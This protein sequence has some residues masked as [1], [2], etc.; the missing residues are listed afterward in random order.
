MTMVD[1]PAALFAGVEPL[2]VFV[3]RL[4][5]KDGIRQRLTD[6]FRLPLRKRRIVRDEIIPD[7]GTCPGCIYR[8]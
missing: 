3:D 8:H 4:V 1:R 2:E 5:Q 7:F 6:E